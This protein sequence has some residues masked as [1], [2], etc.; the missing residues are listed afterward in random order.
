MPVSEQDNLTPDQLVEQAKL[1]QSAREVA[2]M[3]DRALDPEMRHQRD[4][5]SRSNGFALL[6]F[7]LG[8]PPQPATYISNGNREDMIRAIEEWLVRIKATK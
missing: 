1:E 5:E 6:L 2:G 8:D 3:L 4:F 7:K